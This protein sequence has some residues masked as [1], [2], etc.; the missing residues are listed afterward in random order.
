MQDDCN[1]ECREVKACFVFRVFATF[2]VVQTIF[3]YNWNE[4]E[5]DVIDLRRLMNLL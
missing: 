1:A 5:D 3:C 4:G 2:L